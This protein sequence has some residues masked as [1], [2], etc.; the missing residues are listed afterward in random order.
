MH[1]LVPDGHACQIKHF[2]T[3]VELRLGYS[4]VLVVHS[5]RHHRFRG[6]P[7]R[8]YESAVHIH[9]VRT[10]QIEIQN[11]VFE[12]GNRVNLRAPRVSVV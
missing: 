5:V 4:T 6:I 12:A 8:R 9:E 2:V 7:V 1:F 11:L 3:S 10:L